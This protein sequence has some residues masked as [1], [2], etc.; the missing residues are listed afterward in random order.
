MATTTFVD[1]TTTI[2]A[3]W[4][5]DVDALVYQGT[6]SAAATFASTLDVQGAFTSLGI[7]D[8]A[9]AE[10]L[11]VAD[12]LLTVGTDGAN[13][14]MR[15]ASATS[16]LTISSS[17]VHGSS[18]ALYG[19]NHATLASNWYLKTVGSATTISW[20]ESAG[21]LDFYT[22]VGTSKTLAMNITANQSVEP[23][24]FKLPSA[25]TAQLAD[26]GHAINTGDQKVLGS[27]MYNS[28]TH[29]PVYAVGSAHADIWVDG[30]G[31]TVHSPV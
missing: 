21:E 2:V 24:Y 3:A 28:D 29:N 7:N 1:F 31:T 13:Y 5:N 26:V 4:L 16:K 10:R 9:P 20:D 6:H 11:N 8:D 15:G 30:A 18:L 25:T 23:T 12:T 22:K 14:T 17:S 19:N 27:V